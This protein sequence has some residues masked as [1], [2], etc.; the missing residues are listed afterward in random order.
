MATQQ[1]QVWAQGKPLSP[2]AAVLL[3]VLY[4]GDGN[5]RPVSFGDLCDRLG[6][7]VAPDVIKRALAELHKAGM[8]E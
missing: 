5:G 3:V 1:S 7:Q 6:P 2:L 4:W 8:V